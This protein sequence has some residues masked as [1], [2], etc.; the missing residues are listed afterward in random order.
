MDGC[1]RFRR[2]MRRLSWLGRRAIVRSR[3]SGLLW[4]RACG[5]RLGL[6]CNSVVCDFDCAEV[7]ADLGNLT[8]LHKELFHNAVKRA[9]DLDAGLVTL[10]LAK[11]VEGVHGGGR[12]DVPGGREG[13]GMV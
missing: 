7:L 2:R 1:T 13:Q 5:R 9:G 3:R 11:G 4:R 12:L 8:F 10:D 6:L